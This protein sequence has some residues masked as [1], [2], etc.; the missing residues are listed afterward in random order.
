MG[1]YNDNDSFESKDHEIIVLESALRILA[2]KLVNETIKELQ[3]PQT[4]CAINVFQH[5]KEMCIRKLIHETINDARAK[6]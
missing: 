4:A 2:E 5:Q 6:I 1:K 3:Q